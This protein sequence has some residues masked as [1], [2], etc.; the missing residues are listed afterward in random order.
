MAIGQKNGINLM[1]GELQMLQS[2]DVHAYQL[3]NV[4]HLPLYQSK[5]LGI[6]VIYILLDAR[7]AYQLLI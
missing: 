5:K 3:L 7:I 6:S 2:V 1:Y 4:F